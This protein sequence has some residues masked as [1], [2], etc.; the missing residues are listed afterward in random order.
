YVTFVIVFYYFLVYRD[1]FNKIAAEDM[2]YLEDEAKHKIPDF[3]SAN[4][5]YDTVVGP[6][7]A[8]WQSYCTSRPFMYL[9]AYDIRQAENRRIARLIEKE[10]KK[11]RDVAKKKRNEEVRV[12]YFRFRC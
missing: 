1:V 11:V 12:S 9:Q 5:D 7:Y 8:Y 4:S 10:N 3:G 2:N 6:F